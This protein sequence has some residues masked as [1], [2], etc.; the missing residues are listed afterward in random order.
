[1]LTMEQY[2]FPTTAIGSTG[3]LDCTCSCAGVTGAEH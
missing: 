2:R 1:M 3:F